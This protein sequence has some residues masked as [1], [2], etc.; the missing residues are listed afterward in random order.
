MGSR[1]RISSAQGKLLQNI[2]LKRGTRN[3]NRR[4]DWQSDSYPLAIKKEKQLVM[5][6]R[7]A[8][9]AAEMIYARARLVI[10]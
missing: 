3:R 6:D 1:H 10:A 7:S 8:K 4:E 9:A 2:L 5:N